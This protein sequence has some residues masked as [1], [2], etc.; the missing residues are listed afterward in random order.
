MNWQVVEANWLAW[1]IQVLVLSSVG[2][3]A[4]RV[5]K[6][7]DP[8]SRLLGAQLTL[9]ACLIVPFADAWVP[10]P[11]KVNLVTGSYFAG[12]IK[13]RRIPRRRL[14]PWQLAIPALMAAG[15]ILRCGGLTAGLWRLSRYRRSAWIFSD[16]VR[17]AIALTG[18][19]CPVAFSDRAHSPVAFGVFRP[20]ILVPETFSALAQEAQLAILCHELLHVRR[21][22]WLAALA[23]ELCAALFWFQ[24]AIQVLLAD[25]RLAR[26]Q[27]VDGQTV[28]LT[29][30][31]ASYVEALVAIAAEPFGAA[32]SPAPMFLQRRNLKSRVTF[33]LEELYMSKTKM[34]F[35]NVSVAAFLTAAG[36]VATGTFPLV[37]VAQEKSAP[38]A[39]DQA[40][41]DI[42]KAFPPATGKRI[43]VGGNVMS[44]N[45][46][47]QVK[48]TY[49]PSAKAARIQGTVKLG[50]L[51]SPE[52]HV[53]DLVVV[54]GP[55]ELVQSS[56][57]AVRQ[58]LYRPTL[59]NGNPV[60]VVSVVDVNYT[61][62]Q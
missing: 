11:G 21:N 45:L 61:L 1:T 29:R 50:I 51:V 46:I 24:P 39:D 32:I 35:A 12:Q 59:L 31:K 7:T 17:Q 49:P 36:L 43:R 41:V 30:S 22:D 52:G 6:L 3:V 26:E 60:E 14:N 5:L 62:Q 42:N 23:E 33:L 56:A 47:S 57:D 20:V 37:A 25:I 16:T 4:P 2:A 48:P 58:W 34:V 8:K 15:T 13:G 53:T 40:P 38:K 19:L 44:S 9:L 55:P 10:S 54:S 18:T 28:D 27:V